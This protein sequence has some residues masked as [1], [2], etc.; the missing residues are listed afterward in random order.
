MPMKR[1]GIRL[2]AQTGQVELVDNRID[3]LAVAVAD[4]RKA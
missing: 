2:G 4:L 3:G 1:I